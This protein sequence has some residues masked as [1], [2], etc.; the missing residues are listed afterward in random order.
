VKT[1]REKDYSFSC[2][3][4][5]QEPE[6]KRQGGYTEEENLSKSKFFNT[7]AEIERKKLYTRQMSKRDHRAD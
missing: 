4:C 1:E 6:T 5:K 3:K 7:Q 2:D